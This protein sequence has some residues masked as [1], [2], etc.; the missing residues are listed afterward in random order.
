M[1]Q[2]KKC[3]GSFQVDIFVCCFFCVVKHDLLPVDKAALLCVTL[4]YSGFFCVV[5]H[6]LLPVVCIKPHQACKAE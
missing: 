4:L 2:K 1:H 3:A 6:D 5:K